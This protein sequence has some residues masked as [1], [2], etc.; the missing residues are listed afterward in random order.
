M[1]PLKAG[2]DAAR[3]ARA[4]RTPG[5]RRARRP[6]RRVARPRAAGATAGAAVA[7]A[8]ASLG[9][10]ANLSVSL[11]TADFLAFPRGRAHVLARLNVTSLNGTS[12]AALLALLPD[13]F[14]ITLRP[15][16]LRG[17]LGAGAERGHYAFNVYW[18]TARAWMVVVSPRGGSR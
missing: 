1:L 3:R 12:R 8:G 7:D 2:A 17:G 14:D 9:A 11:T 4:P 18:G 13:R 5:R 15:A 10:P 16:L 6:A